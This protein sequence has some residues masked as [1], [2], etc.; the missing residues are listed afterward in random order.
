[1]F[2][3]MSTVSLKG[4]DVRLKVKVRRGPDKTQPWEFLRWK[5]LT[6]RKTATLFV[7]ISPD[8]SLV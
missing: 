2:Q 4:W 8:Y 5:I 3:T 1:M 6:R 7:K